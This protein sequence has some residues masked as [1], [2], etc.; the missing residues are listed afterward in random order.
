MTSLPGLMEV[1][2]VPGIS[3]G[4]VARGQAIWQAHVGAAEKDGAAVGPTTI[5]KAASLSKQV[6]CYAAL[7]LADTVALDLDRPLVFYLGADALP[8]VAARR[9]TA[10]HV[11]TH[12]SGLPNWRQTREIVP[13]FAPGSQFRYSGEGYFLLARCIEKIT[14]VG[15][16]AYMQDAVF[17]PLGM[18][19]STFLWRPDLPER[20]V[21]GHHWEGTPWDDASWRDRLH[22][23]IAAG[24]LPAAQWTLDRVAAAMAPVSGADKG[25]SP[26]PGAIYYPNPAMSLMTTIAD[27]LRIAA[28]F[29]TSFG[30]GLDL[31]PRLRAL[32]A[33]PL[34]RVNRAISWGLGWGNEMADGMSCLFQNGS[35]AGACSSFCL[36]HP[37]SE[38]GMAVF[39]NHINGPRVIDRILRAAT[40][41]EHPVFLWA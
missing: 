6:S 32:A 13:A 20:L 9:I 40:G 7:R 19:S 39:T 23:R 25:V 11:L 37:P 28:R 36:L 29:T 31:S 22:A 4:L 1:A 35:L 27:Y 15:F 41:R 16:E 3:I 24:G 8:D 12:S 26:L 14:G 2:G 5:W 17:E 33:R 30:D 10:R 34:V 38:T 21:P 18:N